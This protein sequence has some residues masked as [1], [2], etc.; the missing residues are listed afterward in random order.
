MCQLGFWVY[1]EILGME[2]V[3]RYDYLRSSV[4]FEMLLITT[5]GS[6]SSAEVEQGL[7]HGQ[8]PRTRWL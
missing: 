8:G 6:A 2:G 5:V 7:E 4:A 1:W 3:M